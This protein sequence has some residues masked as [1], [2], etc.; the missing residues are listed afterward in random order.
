M[1]N[2][3]DNELPTQPDHLNSFNNYGRFYRSLSVND[4]GKVQHYYALSP[5]KTCIDS[6]KS[7]KSLPQNFGEFFEMDQYDVVKER[8]EHSPSED[9]MTDLEELRK[10]NC[11]QRFC[12]PISSGSVRSSIVTLISGCAGVGML[13]L[14]KVMSY[15]GLT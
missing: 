13:G 12:R 10:K 9:E 7:C 1:S 3:F 6:T 15:F 5:E 11:L 14:P 2:D 8:I 4:E